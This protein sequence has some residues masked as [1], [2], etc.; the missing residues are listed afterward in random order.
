MSATVKVIPS[1]DA[2]NAPN[3]ARTVVLANALSVKAELGVVYGVGGY[4]TTTQ[5][6]Q[7]HD[8][9]AAPTNG[10]VPNFVFPITANAPFAVDF[11]IFGM[12]CTRGIQIAFSTTGPTLTLGVAD[13]MAAVRFK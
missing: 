9:A 12:L 2:S 3:N 1:A 7:I 4:S 8:L 11:G 10:A 5:F 13:S 6:L